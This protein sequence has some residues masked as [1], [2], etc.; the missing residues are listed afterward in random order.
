MQKPEHGNA[1]A[2]LVS[3]LN[4]ALG[5]ILVIKFFAA[6]YRQA[7]GKPSPICPQA[8]LGRPFGG[9]TCGGAAALVLERLR[10]L[11]MS[12]PHGRYE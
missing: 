6:W 10:Y 5:Y 7:R 3:F 2:L 11:A 9:D 1:V 8:R 4:L 12:L